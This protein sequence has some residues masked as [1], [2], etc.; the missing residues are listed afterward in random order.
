MR[1]ILLTSLLLLAACA[2]RPSSPDADPFEAR[3][4]MKPVNE[5]VFG[6]N[7][8]ADKYIIRPIARGYHYIPEWGRDGV[9]NFLSNLEEPANVANGI[10]QLDPDLA[11][12]GLWRFVLNST[13]GFAG[14][15]DFAG[16]NGLK[17]RNTN[18]SKTLG[19]YGVEE[20]AYVVLPLAGPSTVRG[21]AGRAVDWFL[22]PV[23]WV[24]PTSLSV[25][26]A[27]ADAVSTR[28]DDAVIIGQLYYKSLEPYTA[29]RAAYL[30]HQAFE[31][32]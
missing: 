14:V 27:A 18:F 32:Q 5:A 23:G 11:L 17:S 25:A 16:E 4:P 31:G 12:N 15:R 19:R 10:L 20:G 7:L 9:S 21:T 6:F 2:S 29:T 13:F 22:D 30:Q 8:G 24:L 28:D 3:D 1:M 26:Q